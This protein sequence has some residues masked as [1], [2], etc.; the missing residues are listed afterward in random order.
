[1]QP[2]S[3]IPYWGLWIRDQGCPERLLPLT[4]HWPAPGGLTVQVTA[5]G[6]A[7]PTAGLQ[8]QGQRGPGPHSTHSPN[9]QM[10]VWI[11]TCLWGLP[12]NRETL[13][14]VDWPASIIEGGC[15]A[16]FR[17]PAAWEKSTSSPLSIGAHGCACK[18]WLT[19][20]APGPGDKVWTEHWPPWHLGFRL[21]MKVPFS[22][23]PTSSLDRHVPVSNPVSL[24]ADSAS[25][26]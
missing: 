11:N 4:F 16:A 1:M 24:P 23:Q 10:Q 21:G 18:W 12:L 17:R 25:S 6:D 22:F 13:A 2:V 26:I 19:S 7:P 9:V 3:L 5:C 20:I 8:L 15:S 14:Q